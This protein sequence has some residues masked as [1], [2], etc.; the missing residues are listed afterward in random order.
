[1]AVGSIPEELVAIGMYA[2]FRDLMLGTCR[3]QQLWV[4]ESVAKQVSLV[5]HASPG[6]QPICPTVPLLREL[7]E[8]ANC[9][10][11]HRVYAIQEPPVLQ[12]F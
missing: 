4:Q 7:C 12:A 1:M 3:Q 8:T 2:V 10:Y 6:A 5:L 11:R 9:Q